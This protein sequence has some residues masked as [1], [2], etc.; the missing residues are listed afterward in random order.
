MSLAAADDPLLGRVVADRFRLEDRLGEGSLG[1]VYRAR[2]LLIDRTVAIKVLCVPPAHRERYRAW[3]LREARAVNRVNHANLV[4][5]Y[6]YGETDDGTVYLV[7]ELLLGERLADRIA[8][9][10]LG[11]SASLSI[12]EQAASALGRAHELGVVHRDLKPEHVFL[13]DRGG[14]RD[15]VKLIDFGL[16]HI[17]WEGRL[18]A[19]GAVLGTPEY[20]SPEQA[21]GEDAGPQADLYSLGVVLFEMLTGR[22]PFTAP[23]PAAL[24]A[25]HLREPAPDPRS[26]RDD[27]DPEVAEMTLRLLEKDLGRRYRDAHHLV[28]DCKA[29]LRRL[30]PPEAAP[31]DVVHARGAAPALPLGGASRWALGASLL[32][33]MA[34]AAYPG[35]AAPETIARAVGRVWGL[36]ADLARVDGELQVLESWNE[37]LWSRSRESAARLG[38]ELE[39]TARLASRLARESA[40]GEAG[41]VRLSEARRRAE[42]ELQAARDEADQLESSGDIPG[43]RRALEAAGAAA[44]RQQQGLDATS[45]LTAELRRAEGAQRQAEGRAARLREQ[46]E[47]EASRTEADLASGRPRI[48]ALVREREALLG[49][50]RRGEETL[51][52]HFVKRAECRSLL[53][54]LSG[55]GD[56]DAGPASR[57]AEAGA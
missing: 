14:R 38:R 40:E 57:A 12:V 33:R 32:G 3:F 44:A 24:L 52:S 6:D 9:G 31:A 53:T 29:V 37:N 43:I 19:P 47:R 27:V 51:R 1:A 13:L 8:L 16:A 23:D 25:C 20:L 54:E 10:P 56:P 39:E 42:E 28:D 4:E 36:V 30:G 46:L 5:V 55:L 7:M 18:S 35:G 26:L 45:R 15:F 48:A 34:A 11:A 50:L 17:D 2:H 41:L 49:E 22:L 21:R